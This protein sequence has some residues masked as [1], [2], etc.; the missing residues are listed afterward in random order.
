MTGNRATRRL[1]SGQTLEA[2]EILADGGTIAIPTETVYGLGADASNDDAV[3]EVFEAKGRP[4]GHPLI[5]HLATFAQVGEWARLDDERM[6]VLADAFWPGPLTIIVPRTDRVSPLVVGGRDTVGI[7][8]PSHPVAHEVLAA[9][10]GG[11]AAPSANR[12]G[13][14]SPT[15]AEHVLADLD[16]R[17]DAVIDGGSSEVG[18]ESTIVELVGRDPVLLRPG[19][20]SRRRLEETLGQPVIDGRGGESRAAGMLASHYAPRAQV[21]IGTAS[22]VSALA[23]EDST[24]GVIGPVET[25]HTNRWWLPADAKSYAEGLYAALRA[26]D[27]AGV[28]RIFVVPPTHGELLDAVLDRLDKAAAD[29]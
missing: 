20:I 17:I 12:F 25:R 24:V 22:S 13:H 7:R 6:A 1:S 27:A 9:F 11:V 2:A 10:G 15:T 4:I 5:V 18:L 19:G 16:G 26:A 3:R 8:I 23:P 14:V 28:E 21:S 29:R